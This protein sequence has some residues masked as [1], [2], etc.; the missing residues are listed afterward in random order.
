[1]LIQTQIR[2]PLSS[3]CGAVWLKIQTL[4]QL[5][6]SYGRNRKTIKE[7]IRPTERLK[8]IKARLSKQ[9]HFTLV[10]KFLCQKHKEQLLSS[11]LFCYCNSETS[12]LNKIWGILKPLKKVRQMQ[13]TQ[14]FS[15]PD[16]TMLRI[17]FNLLYEKM[18]LQI[19]LWF[20]ADTHSR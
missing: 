19:A 16:Y 18:E 3:E 20:Q 12:I 13:G 5:F 4:E 7:H 15:T 9:A 2:A 8:G 11:G 10:N 17:P 6:C 14:L 1:M